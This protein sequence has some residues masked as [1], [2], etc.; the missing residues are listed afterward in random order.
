MPGMDEMAEHIVGLL[1][2]RFEAESSWAEF[3]ELL[4]DGLGLEAALQKVRLSHEM[5]KAVVMSTWEF[6]NAADQRIYEEYLV[7]RKRLPLADLLNIFLSA[8]PKK[9][10]IVT[11]NY[12]RLAE[13]SIDQAQAFL[14]SGFYGQYI[15]H[16]AG[17]DLIPYNPD[18]RV[19]TLLKV[20]G[21]LDWLDLLTSLSCCLE[22]LLAPQITIH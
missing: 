5:H 13:Y 15:G 22:H 20:H 18:E 2:D 12:D 1:S 3:R 11:T 8:H 17:V 6:I 9:A 14:A 16:F 4:A 10:T 21:S 19:V 7:Q